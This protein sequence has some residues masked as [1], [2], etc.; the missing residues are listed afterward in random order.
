M[1][2]RE[3]ILNIL[4]TILYSMAII[5]PITHLTEIG[6]MAQLTH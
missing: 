5:M 3:R 4:G 6:Q 1:K 2:Q